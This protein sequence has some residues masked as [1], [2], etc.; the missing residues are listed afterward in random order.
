MSA[1]SKLLMQGVFQYEITHFLLNLME[2]RFMEFIRKLHDLCQKHNGPDRVQENFVL[3]LEHI[4]HWGEEVMRQEVSA[5]QL[6]CSEL[7]GVYKQVLTK[8]LGELFKDMSRKDTHNVYVPSLTKFI[9]TF[10]MMAGSSDAVRS[11][12]IFQLCPTERKCVFL[13]AMRDTLNDILREP[14]SALIRELTPRSAQSSYSAN[15]PRT[16]KSVAATPAQTQ[17]TQQQQPVEPETPDPV[18]VFNQYVGHALKA[19]ETPRSTISTSQGAAA[20]AGPAQPVNTP[21]T[22]NGGGGRGPPSARPPRTP[23]TNSAAAS[24]SSVKPTTPRS[25]QPKA[26]PTPRSLSQQPH[27]LRREP[28]AA[29]PPSSSHGDRS[30][31]L[32][33]ASKSMHTP[34]SVLSSYA[35]PHSVPSYYQPDISKQALMDSVSSKDVPVRKF[36]PP[37]DALARLPVKPPSVREVGSIKEIR[38]NSPDTASRARERKLRELEAEDEDTDSA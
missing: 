37:P 28:A 23:A 27:S 10:F 13:E 31:S 7:E 22:A 25:R 9:K 18:S 16:A 21:K 34:T 2:H 6:S 36:V 26:A 11:M 3:G 15:T 14:I 32:A 29:G 8:H 12:H 24:A 17:S 20:A 5:L 35:T 1:D 30:S 38:I 4:S 33:E 19:V